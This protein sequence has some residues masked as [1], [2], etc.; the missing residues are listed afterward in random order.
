MLK[1]TAQ[2]PQKEK[3]LL[4][5]R[6]I[7]RF[8]ALLYFWTIVTA[9]IAQSTPK[10]TNMMLFE[11]GPEANLDAWRTVND[12]VM[13][14]VSRSVFMRESDSTAV[15]KGK[16]SPENNGGFASVR[17]TLAENLSMGC[18]SLAIRVKGDG[19]TYSLRC[20]T[21]DGLGGVSYDAP[22]T[23]V[24]DQWT[25]HSFLL[26]DFAPVFRGRPVPDAPTLRSEKIR[27]IG[28][29]IAGKQFG[30]FEL[31]IDHIRCAYEISN[32]DE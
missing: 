32:T 8:G 24:N 23:T 5:T 6:I 9:S 17:T 31:S 2:V 18:A 16:V 19:K 28:F 13:G 25:E 4:P 10:D 21:D 29:L 7:G 3:H 14:G 26:T 1:K 15:F 30:R 22:F 12:G 27:Q 11:F 20:H